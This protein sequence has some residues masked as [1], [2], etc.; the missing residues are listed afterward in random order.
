MTFGGWPP[1]RVWAT[2]NLYFMY[3]YIY[4]E[5]YLHQDSIT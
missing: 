4:V 2:Y 3:I 1:G 5:T